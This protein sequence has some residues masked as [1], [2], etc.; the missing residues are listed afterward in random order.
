MS[1]WVLQTWEDIK[2]EKAMLTVS[3]GSSVSYLLR[4]IKSTP[5]YGELAGSL[6]HL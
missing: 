6:F 3:C 5:L 2:V 1:F 4:F